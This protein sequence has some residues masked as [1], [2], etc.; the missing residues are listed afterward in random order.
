MK[1]Y[2]LRATVT[3]PVAGLMR[4]QF[5]THPHHQT[6]V[7]KNKSHFNHKHWWNRNHVTVCVLSFCLSVGL[8]PSRFWF[9]LEFC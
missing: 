4:F 5:Y 6:R 9:G 3:Q 8:S 7:E 2:P 1:L